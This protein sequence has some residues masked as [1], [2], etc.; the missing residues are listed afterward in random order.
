MGIRER[1]EREKDAT[2]RAILDAARA[3]FVQEGFANISIR[4]IA[5]RVEY[6]PAAIYTYF[7]S[8]D[9][10]LCALAQEGF[11]LLG[12]HRSRRGL[13]QLEP[14][15]AIRA[16]FRRLYQFSKD[17]PEY[18]ALMFFERSIPR[19]AREHPHFEEIL[20]QRRK[21]MAV[22]DRCADGKL[23]PASVSSLAIFRVVS[24]GL[25]GVIALRLA[26]RLLDRVADRLAADTVE[27]AIAGLRAGSHV[28]YR[29][30]LDATFSRPLTLRR[31]EPPIR[32]TA[33]TRVRDQVR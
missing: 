19:L 6:S 27:A 1:Q 20:E 16:V 24:M 30:D 23:F 18:F 17:Q 7:P 21:L 3:L 32:G 22:L 25:F 8:K 31:L 4:R 13:D 29:A 10:I 2:R 28:S 11:E 15:D 26:G 12:A 9:E 14:L 5:E 33:R